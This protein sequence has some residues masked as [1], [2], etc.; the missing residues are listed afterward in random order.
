MYGNYGD[1]LAPCPPDAEARVPGRQHA[2]I[3]PAANGQIR[4][5]RKGEC[6]HRIFGNESRG[7][8]DLKWLTRRV[9]DAVPMMPY[10]ED[11][12]IVPKSQFGQN[13]ERPQTSFRDRK[14]R[15]AIS[16]DLLTGGLLNTILSARC[17]LPKL[18]RAE[19]V[20]QAMPIGMAGRLMTSAHYLANDL[21]C[22]SATQPRMKKVAFTPLSSKRSISW[23]VFLSTR[24]GYWPHSSRLITLRTLRLENNLQHRPK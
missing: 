12:R 3:A 18:A 23:R 2:Q 7:S 11:A 20:N 6:R 21:G 5:A 9:G 14:A 13:V 16:Q 19:I 24:D 10:W 1:A 4:R 8:C 22:F 17:V 15:S